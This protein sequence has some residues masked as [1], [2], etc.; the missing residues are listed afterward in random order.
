MDRVDQI[1]L[2]ACR[3]GE[4]QDVVQVARHVHEIRHVVVEER[5]P[6]LADQV[7]NVLH[8]ARQKVVHHHH[9]VLPSEQILAEVRSE[10]SGPARY[11]YAHS[12]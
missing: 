10:E 9:L 11:Q 5:E 3:A 1:V 4:V 8:P 6:R 12:P 2:G 7:R